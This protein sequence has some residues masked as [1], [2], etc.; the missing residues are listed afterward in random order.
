MMSHAR[1]TFGAVAA[2]ALIVVQVALADAADPR[3]Q[4]V[5]QPTAADTARAK[6][7]LLRRS[8]L[9][10]QFQ[11]QSQRSQTPRLPTCA[12]YPGDRSDI[13]I[14]GSA[15]TSFQLRG[16]AGRPVGNRVAS[17]AFFFETAS[18]SDR[19]WQKTVRPEFVTCL[20]ASL[21]FGTATKPVRPHRIVLAKEVFLGPV[22]AEK[23]VAYRVIADIR[24]PGKERIYLTETAAFVKVGRAIAA[25]RITEVDHVCMCHTP[26]AR[27]VAARLTAAAA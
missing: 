27:D 15:N 5:E 4:P 20:A 2:L 24:L 25:F 17:S 22:G 11:V 13:T 21:V 14:T 23:A 16:K 26:I 7:S 12:T 8:D 9:A 1:R 3:K 10:A 18:D 6:S 19:Y